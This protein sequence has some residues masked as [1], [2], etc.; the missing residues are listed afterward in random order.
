MITRH[1]VFVGKACFQF[2]VQ[3]PHHNGKKHGTQFFFSQ[4]TSN[5]FYTIQKP[6]VVQQLKS[7]ATKL[8]VLAKFGHILIPGEHNIVNCFN[9]LT[10]PYDVGIDCQSTGKYRKIILTNIIFRL[11][12]RERFSV[13]PLAHCDRSG[14]NLTSQQTLSDC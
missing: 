10:F 4:C 5:Q 8:Y 6:C 2:L 9:A 1:K 13:R 11:I 14:H 12:T 3:W 7:L